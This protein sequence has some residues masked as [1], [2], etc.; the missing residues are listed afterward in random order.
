MKQSELL[1]ADYLAVDAKLYNIICDL[2]EPLGTVDLEENEQFNLNRSDDT[3]K[4]LY[5]NPSN[6]TASIEVEDTEGELSEWSLA[7]LELT[8]FED[9]VELLRILEKRTGSVTGH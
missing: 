6:K 1:H 9:R 4:R 5:I 8:N 7:D 3:A 2:L